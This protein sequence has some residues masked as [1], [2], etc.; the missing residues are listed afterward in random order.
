[1]KPYYEDAG[2]T[3]YNADCRDVLQDLDPVDLVVT[4]PPYNLNK[5]Y[6][7]GGNTEI[8]AKMQKKYGEWYADDMPEEEYLKWQREIIG[9]L[10][11]V[12][13]GSVFYNH[14]LRYAWH[15]RNTYRTPSN[16]Y[17]PWEIVKGFPVWSEIIWDR[18]APDKPNHRYRLQHEYI[19]Q[20]GKPVVD[21][22][23]SGFG[24]GIWRIPADS[25]SHVCSFPIQIP[26]RCIEDCTDPAG[27]VL[28][29][30]M[31]SGTT[32]RAAKDLRRRGIGI[33]IDE[34]CCELAA[35]RLSQEVFDF[36][37]LQHSPT[38]HHKGESE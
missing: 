9:A 12:C 31:G 30:F 28:D 7:G 38:E 37:E 25:T 21:R 24:T 11:A 5:R 32:I 27:T 1:M 26:L 2:M 16:C 8:C 4:S 14:K 17:H 36:G 13:K 29:P 35:K 19:Y 6:S 10:M 20:L 23:K 18:C 33:E 15:G 3:I 22:G 34:E